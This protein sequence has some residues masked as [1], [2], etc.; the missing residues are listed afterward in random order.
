[1][2]PRAAV[3]LGVSVFMGANVET[4]ASSLQTD[5]T[6]ILIVWLV[7]LLLLELVLEGVTVWTRGRGEGLEGVAVRTRGRGESL[8]GVA[9]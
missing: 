8:E 3:N 6:V 5:L 2:L 4:I 1:M 9:V 7:A